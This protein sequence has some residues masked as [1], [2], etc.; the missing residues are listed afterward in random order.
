MFIEDPYRTNTQGL[1]Y[2]WFCITMLPLL[3]AIPKAADTLMLGFLMD[4]D[5]C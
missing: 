1:M 2:I 5:N 3:L 4:V